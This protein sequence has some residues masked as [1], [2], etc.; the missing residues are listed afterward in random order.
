MITF[1]PDRH[2]GVFVSISAKKGFPTRLVFSCD[3]TLQHIFR[4]HDTYS[5]LLNDRNYKG[6]FERVGWSIPSHKNYVFEYTS[7]GKSDV[8][9]ST[10]G[11]F[12]C[13][14]T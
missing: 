5:F 10:K 8:N 12:T 14:S 11:Y 9:L 6:V 13:Q 7:V 1:T 2:K 4:Q 3:Y